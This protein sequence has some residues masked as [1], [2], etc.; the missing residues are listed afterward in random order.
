MKD[1]SRRIA[2]YRLILLS[3]LGFVGVAPLHAEAQAEN[4]SQ[5]SEKSQVEV[6][7]TGSL[8]PTT[9]FI[10]LMRAI[11]LRGASLFEYAPH[12]VILTFMA[13]ALFT[14]CALRFQKKIG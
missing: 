11:I 8:L 4:D 10:S 1:R 3:A 2:G 12:L 7:V 14:V 6:V 5:E 13:I 9:Y